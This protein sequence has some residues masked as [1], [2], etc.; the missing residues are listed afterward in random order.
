M[1]NETMFKMILK[2]RGNEYKDEIIKMIEHIPEEVTFKS[3]RKEI[4]ESGKMTY[5]DQLMLNLNVDFE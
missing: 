1:N 5:L 2:E 3:L 4:P